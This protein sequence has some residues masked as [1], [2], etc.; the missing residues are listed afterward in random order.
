MGGV[1]MSLSDVIILALAAWRVASLLVNE[2]GP[3]A[4]FSRLRYAAGIRTWCD[5]G[6]RCRSR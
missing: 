2:D 3:G 1:D 4:V 6:R 5:K